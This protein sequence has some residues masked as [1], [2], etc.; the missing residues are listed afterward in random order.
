MGLVQSCQS[1]LLPNA[2]LFTMLPNSTISREDGA[3]YLGLSVVAAT[4]LFI[5]SKAKV[6]LTPGKRVNIAPKVQNN[7]WI[8]EA[9]YLQ[10]ATIVDS[11]LPSLSVNEASDEVIMSALKKLG[12][13]DTIDNMPLTVKDLSKHRSYLCAGALDYGTHRHCVET[14]GKVLSVEE[15]NKVSSILNVL[16]TS[17]GSLVLTGY[18]V[19]FSELPLSLREKVLFTWRD[20]SLAPIRSLFQLF[21]RL[22]SVH[23]IACLNDANDPKTD[24]PGWEGMGY[25]PDSSRQN[26]TFTAKDDDNDRILRS[27]VGTL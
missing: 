24:N 3:F 7:D 16:S 11:F 13:D 2:S 8:S 12:L 15:R 18:A 5:Y 4:S 25:R 21:K 27:Q 26:V 22:V 10:L 6:A 17:A 23:Y 19:P 14:I 20:S 9:A 1:L